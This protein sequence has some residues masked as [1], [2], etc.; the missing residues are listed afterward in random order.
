MKSAARTP[1]LEL[2]D[3][4]RSRVERVWS[5]NDRWFTPAILIIML[6][7]AFFRTWNLDTTPPGLLEAE[8]NNIQIAETV[9]QGNISVVYDEVQPAREGLY[10]YILA[11]MKLIAGDGGLILW[12]MPSVW[13]SMLFLAV[14]ARLMRR[15]YG[16]RVAVLAVGL[17]A[18]SFWPVWIGR[19]ALHVTLLPLATVSIGYILL[20]AFQT[21]DDATSSLWFTIG[22]LAL[23]LV[24]Y[25][26]I[27]AWTLLALFLLFIGYRAMVR[28]DDIRAQGTNIVY[29]LVLAGII[30]MPLLIY[31]A[32]NPGVREIVPLEE[33]SRL[34]LEIP[35][36][37]VTSI[38]GLVLRGDTLPEHNLPGRPAM[39][40]FVGMLMVIGIG[41]SMARWR[42]PQHGFALLWLVV[43]LIPTA[44]LPHK[45]DFE[46]M[47]VIMPVAYAFPAVGLYA[48]MKAVRKRVNNKPRRLDVTMGFGVLLMV[49]LMF[50]TV[51]TYRDYFI[52]WPQN[53]IVRLAYQADYGLLAHYLD[54]SEDRSPVSI[55]SLPLPVDTSDPFALTSREKLA[56]FMHRENTSIRYFDC[57]Q[58]LVLAQAGES[59]RIVFPSQT[60]EDVLPGPLL[61]WMGDA[62]PEDVP[63]L[64]EGVVMRIEVADKLAQR[65]GAFITTASTAWPPEIG[66]F[67]SAELPV[68]FGSNMTFLG[69]GLRRSH[70]RPGEYIQLTSYWRVDGTPPPELREFAHLLG[71]PVVVLSQ[72][73]GLGV[74]ITTLQERDIFL[75]YAEIQVPP[76]ARADSY[77]LSLGLYYPTTGERLPVFEGGDVLANRLYLQSVTVLR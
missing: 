30:M 15:L 4:E 73:D 22:G 17:M 64:R 7:G 28:R 38:A 41:V 32:R 48:I 70:L 35:G 75:Q 59:Q 5:R 65:A 51:I 50:N 66:A 11:A 18:V 19:A 67:R 1:D 56:Y 43:G 14:S 2:V 12:R 53:G 33:Q 60:Y 9:L 76:Q 77:S 24:Q 68:R 63:G 71:N 16:P 6:A 29:A 61:I 8:L 23:G 54:T 3:V 13:A 44:F 42:K 47:A 36:R 69:Y 62:Q 55:C 72:N 37:I 46:M 57:T 31:L 40:P 58:A 49:V 25:V 45:P 27:S 52:R 20:R 10:Y 34:L 26:H 21:L 74:D 39:G